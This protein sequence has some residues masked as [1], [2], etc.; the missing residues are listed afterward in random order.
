MRKLLILSIFFTACT[1]WASNTAVIDITDLAGRHI[2]VPKNLQRI[3]CIAPGCLRLI[4]YL[5]AT[6]RLVGVERMEK[7]QPHGRPYW[8]AHPE[9]NELPIIGP[10]GM[11]SINQYPDFESIL[12][13]KPDIIFITY[14]DADKADKI[15]KLTDIPVVVLS[16]G[17]FG[18]FDSTL[19]TSIR[20]VGK[21]LKK[22]KR[23]EEVVAFIETHKKELLKRS[24]SYAKKNR[25][26]VYVGGLGFK[27]VSGIESS[28]SSFVPFTWTN[29]DNAVKTT[30]L[31]EHVAVDRETLLKLNPDF[32]FITGGAP[33]L[34]TQD[35]Y[36]KQ[37]YFNTLKAFKNKNVYSLYPFNWYMTNIGTAIIDAYTVG[38]KLYPESFKNI[39]L[40]N[41]SNEVYSFLTGKPV[42]EMMKKYYGKLGEVINAER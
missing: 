2:S 38:K 35:L 12:K 3:I 36:R 14:M 24:S 6:D 40:K 26:S 27:G 33:V 15:A 7:Q 31:E 5:K 1:I 23:A 39:D 25:P 28:S 18:S 9:L 8:L 30:P 32:I 16:Y 42:Y 13:V 29:A 22:E 4:V 41:K 17:P 37:K 19:Y 21:I 34:L 10:G 11:N 20:L